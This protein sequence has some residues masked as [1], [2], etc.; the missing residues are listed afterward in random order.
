MERKA[1]IIL[2][3]AVI[4]FIG[5]GCKRERVNP[6]DPEFSPVQVREQTSDTSG[7]VTFVTGE[8]TIQ[9]KIVDHLTQ[10]PLAGIKC[11]EI[12]SEHGVIY[13]IVD[14]TGQ[15]YSA[16][17]VPPKESK[18]KDIIS[19]TK[20]LIQVIRGAVTDEKQE[21]IEILHSDWAN[22]ITRRMVEEI[23]NGFYYKKYEFTF[24][25]F[26]EKVERALKECAIMFGVEAVAG[27][28]LTIA[29]GGAYGVI[30]A[31]QDGLSIIHYGVE[32]SCIILYAVELERLYRSLGYNDAEKFQW[33]QHAFLPEYCIIPM[34]P[35][36]GSPPADTF[37]CIQGYV[38]SATTGEPL[39]NVRICLTPLAKQTTTDYYG[40]YKLTGL[41]EGYYDLTA[42]LLGY[43][44]SIRESVYV[45]SHDTRRVDFALSPSIIGRAEYRIVLTW[46]EHPRDLDGH[47]WT[48]EIDG[49]SYH[50]CWYS[51]GDSA[52]TPYVWQDVDDVTSYGPETI[53]LVKVFPGYYKYAVYDYS[54]DGTITTSQA[55]VELYHG[56]QLVKAWEVPAGYSEPHWWWYVFDLNAV[57][58]EIIEKNLIQS[59]PPGPDGGKGLKSEIKRFFI[60][61]IDYRRRHIIG[62][63]NE[64]G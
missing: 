41:T 14:T 32:T 50:I 17:T 51:M 54:G 28:V 53:T 58:G 36:K 2:L 24:D 19:W 13:Y 59:E 7:I 30:S 29:T 35:P 9:I 26:D 15:Y 37:S 25:E 3:V 23:L 33:W 31:V 61:A 38:T 49:I 6:F 44:T 4:A 63:N 55:R 1:T 64:R 42:S 46:G 48:P 56:R 40:F 57:T 34:E 62:S 60:K 11:C 18:G 47:V 45:G 21:I 27:V 16:L 43:N 22:V 52:D 39:E 5:G 10:E 12:K 8:E 20:G